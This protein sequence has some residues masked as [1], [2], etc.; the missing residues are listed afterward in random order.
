MAT[1]PVRAVEAFGR[2]ALKAEG[3]VI[4]KDNNVYGGGRNGIMYKV[5]PDGKVSELVTL[6][7]GSIPN[8]VT[9]DRNGDLV[10]CDLGKE[11]VA[12]VTQSGKVSMVADRAG[13]LHLSMPN[14]ATYDAEGNLFVSNSST[15][16]INNVLPELL[17]PSPKGA[18][19]VI[20][21]NG[22]SEVVASGMDIANG[23][24]IDPK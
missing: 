4:D 9:M 19:V 2:G 17:N 5:T 7:A 6:P 21:A 20:R 13:D 1:F 11:A 18:L 14:F 23:T 12:R 15:S 22:K 10:Y 24:A 3:V 8:G 16:T